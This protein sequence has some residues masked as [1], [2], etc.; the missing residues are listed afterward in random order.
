MPNAAAVP[1]PPCRPT[2]GGSSHYLQR[3]NTA[4]LTSRLSRSDLFFT[5][6]APDPVERGLIQK[7][8]R[9]GLIMLLS[10][11]HL[12]EQREAEESN[13][14]KGGLHTSR[15]FHFLCTALVVF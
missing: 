12:K 8:H 2:P 10:F 11:L 14:G 3:F 5:E 1:A 6:K 9:A 4:L 13:Q 15:F 7:V